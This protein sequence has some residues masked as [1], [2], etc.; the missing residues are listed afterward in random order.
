MHPTSPTA[1]TFP[2]I[3]IGPYICVFVS[4]LI[5][6]RPSCLSRLCCPSC[7][8]EVF[9]EIASGSLSYDVHAS[10]SITYLLVDF[11]GGGRARRRHVRR[12][13]LRS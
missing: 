6:S 10:V 5:S 3:I 13:V 1:L 11:C 8:S 9:A 4:S 2:H 7:I 12:Y